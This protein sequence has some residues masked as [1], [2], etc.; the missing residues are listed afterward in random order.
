MRLIHY[1]PKKIDALESQKYDQYEIKFQS[2]PNGLWFSVEGLDGWKEW[3]KGE[4]TFL[5]RL[6]FSYEIILKEKTNIIHLKTPEEIFSFTKK[7]PLKKRGYDSDS[8]TSELDWVEI[9]TNYQGI[10]IS[11]YQ[12]DCRLALESGW[13]YGWDCSSGCIW[14]ISCIQDFIFLEEN[15]EM[16]TEP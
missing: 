15:L 3:C 9:K 7:Y 12:W 2:K 4:K 1:S 6:R 5:D 14:D 16:P 11:P 13:Y 10:I 8:D